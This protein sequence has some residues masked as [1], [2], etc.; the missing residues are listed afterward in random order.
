MISSPTIVP[1]STKM[2]NSRKNFIDPITEKGQG[3]FLVLI[4]SVPVNQ[5]AKTR[6]FHEKKYS[7]PTMLL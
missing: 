2:C 6:F 3:I 5:S 4:S 1:F 7:T